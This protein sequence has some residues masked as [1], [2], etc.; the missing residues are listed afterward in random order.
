MLDHTDIVEMVEQGVSGTR[1]EIVLTSILSTFPRLPL[2]LQPLVHAG[3][4]F[5]RRVLITTTMSV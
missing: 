2:Q 5:Q 3:V 4:R 1:P